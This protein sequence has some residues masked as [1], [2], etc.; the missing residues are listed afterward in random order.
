MAVILDD[1]VRSAIARRRARGR[2]VAITLTVVKPRCMPAMLSARWGEPRP[3][4]R[5][6]A[7]RDSERQVA[8]YLGPRVARYTAEHDITITMPRLGPF[9]RLM[10]VGETGVMLELEDWERA[11]ATGTQARQSAGTAGP[12]HNPP[13]PGG[14]QGRRV[15]RG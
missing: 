1:R 12:R 15:A 4:Q 3:W 2:A 10:V 7:A 11:A 9:A 13:E 8:L 5:S 6:L 14:A